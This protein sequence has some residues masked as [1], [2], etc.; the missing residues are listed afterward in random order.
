VRAALLALALL[1]SSVSAAAAQTLPP[2]DAGCE[3]VVQF[4]NTGTPG[5]PGVSP[6]RRFGVRLNVEGTAYVVLP[7][8]ARGF[9]RFYIARD[10][11]V[12]FSV[13]P[14]YLNYA[15]TQQ[16]FDQEG[17]GPGDQPASCGFMPIQVPAGT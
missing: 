11:Q 9:V 8:D 17:I 7:A 15:Y 14:L 3:V 2:A 5:T 10:Q 1:V 12:S 16:G 13:V 6:D 4:F